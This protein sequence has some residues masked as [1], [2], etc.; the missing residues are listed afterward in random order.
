MKSK[1]NVQRT[2]CSVPV[3]NIFL[4]LTLL[5]SY[6]QVINLVLLGDFAGIDNLLYRILGVV[7]IYLRR[8]VK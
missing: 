4:N 5:L 2:M 8:K 7:V 6:A 3:L 1:S